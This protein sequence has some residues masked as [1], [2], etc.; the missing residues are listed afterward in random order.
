MQQDKRLWY[1]RPIVAAGG[2]LALAGCGVAAA[3]F[4]TGPDDERAAPGG[5]SP[6]A[7][8]TPPSAQSPQAPKSAPSGQSGESAPTAAPQPAAP[9][10]RICADRSV[11]DGPATPPSGAVRVNPPADLGALTERHPPGTTFW[12]APG[13]HRLPRGAYSQVKAKNGNTYIGAPGA[14]LDG[15]RSNRYAFTGDATGVTIRNLTVQNFGAPRSTNDEGVVNHD[16]AVGWVIERNTIQNNAGAGVMIGSRNQIRSNCLSANGQYGFNAYHKDDVA[17]IVIEHNEIAGNNTDDWETL[18][19]GCGCTGGGKFWAVR[20]AVIRNN[21]VHHNLSA[22]LW[23]DTNNTAFTIEGN[24][25]SDNSAEGI[26]YETSYTAAIRHNTFVRNGV[27]KG[28][29]NKGFPTSAVYVS[30]SGSDERVPGDHGKSFEIS[31]NLFVDNWAGVILWENSDRFVGSPANTSTDAS[32]LVN[33][34]VVNARTCNESTITRKPYIDDCRWKT[35]NVRVHHNRFSLDPNKIG[36]SCALRSGCGFNGLFSNWGTFPDWSP[37]HED[38]V[39]EAITF[40]QGNTF[41]ANSYAGP[42]Q[43][44]VHEQGKNVNWVTWQGAPY[45]QDRD[46]V[47]MLPTPGGR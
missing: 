19:P 13:V 46:S 42:W 20:G 27:A 2:V 32:T 21:W 30:E 38:V 28:P 14:I 15:Q 29:T 39:Q 47:I 6:P 36:S 26:I 25:I 16:S 40:R 18:R 5:D 43:F 37:F 11:L 22:G 34:T 44:V 33:P 31:D 24:L 17:A 45:G 23:A 9:P 35:K 3:V 7:A 8:Q 10:A 41:Y 1:R 12:L 4:L